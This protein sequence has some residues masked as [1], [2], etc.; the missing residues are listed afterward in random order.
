MRP[1]SP[2]PLA[3]DASVGALTTRLRDV[4]RTLSEALRD[5]G[6]EVASV[7]TVTAHTTATEMDVLIR[8]DATGGAVTVT[9]PSAR[10]ILGHRLMVIRLNGGANAVTVAAAA[11]ETINGAATKALGAQY[12]GTTLVAWQ[13][14][15]TYGFDAF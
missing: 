13:D 2:D 4:L 7:R 12:A 14:G 11:G 10:T 15:T 6:P 1:W 9:L 8:A 3:N 5:A